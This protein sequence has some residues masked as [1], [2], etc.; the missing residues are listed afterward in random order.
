MI[1]GDDNMALNYK[2]KIY[3]NRKLILNAKK[4]K[5]NSLKVKMLIENAS[6]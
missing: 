4:E 3:E 6:G 2:T 1:V 5:L